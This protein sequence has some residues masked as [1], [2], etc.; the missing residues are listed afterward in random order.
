MPVTLKDVIVFVALVSGATGIRLG[1][2][3]WSFG[4][5]LGQTERIK[6]YPARR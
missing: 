4:I 6:K 5:V 1:L 2:G 3:T